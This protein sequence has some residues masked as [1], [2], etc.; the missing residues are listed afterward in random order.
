VNRIKLQAAKVQL[1][2]HLLAK[3]SARK[4]EAAADVEV[5]AESEVEIEDH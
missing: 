5:N 2:L 1:S 4:I 3:F